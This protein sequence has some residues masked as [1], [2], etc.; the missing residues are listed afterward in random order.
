VLCF[1]AVRMTGTTIG[2]T[3]DKW[4]RNGRQAG[5]NAVAEDFAVVGRIDYTAV[6]GLFLG[7]S[8][9]HGNS[10]QGERYNGEKIDGTV[11]I[12]E[13][14]GKYRFKEF[15][16]TGIYVSGSLSDAD[17]ISLYNGEVIGKNVYGY[18][19]NLAYDVAQ[20]LGKDFNLP[21]FVRY[22]RYNTQDKVPSGFTA[23]PNN[24]KTVWTVGINYRPIPNVVLKADYQFRDNKGSGEA[25]IFELG[26][27]FIF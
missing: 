22:E 11:T 25:D 3:S 18:Y 12:Y 15:E 26:L 27:G 10:G 2:F 20:K 4:V 24:D 9:Y 21:V 19:L 16:L 8:V 23:D 17:K 1:S 7:A 5:A 6:D 14:H 13:I